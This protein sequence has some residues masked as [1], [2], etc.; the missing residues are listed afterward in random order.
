MNLAFERHYLLIFSMMVLLVS[1][2]LPF[3]ASADIITVSDN[4]G[5]YSSI[6][7]AIEDANSGDTLLIT[8]GIYEGNFTV[9]KKLTLEG[10]EGSEI[11]VT[12]KA[13]GRPVITIGP[14]SVE[15]TLV[16][17]RLHRAQGNICNDMAGGACPSG[18][19][20]TGRSSVRL[21]N[22]SLAENGREGLRIGGTARVK[23]EN[24]KIV[25]NDRYGIWLTGSSSLTVEDT[26]I[27]NNRNAVTAAKSTRVD[28]SNSKISSS[29]GYGISLFGRANLNLNDSRLA[30]NGQGGIRLENS[31]SGTLKENSINGNA[32]P[33][34][35]LQ[36]STSLK[37]VNNL[38]KGNQIGV[39]NHSTG[40]VVFKSNKILRNSIDL[41]GNLDGEL[42]TRYPKDKVDNIFLPNQ[43]YPTFQAAVDALL[44]GGTITLRANTSGGGVID[45]QMTIR[46]EN[47]P[48][49]LTWPRETGSP[50]LSL[51][52]GADLTILDTEISGS[53][54]SGIVLGG[55]AQLQIKSSNISN[56]SEE[57]LGLWDSSRV[58]IEKSKIAGNEGSGVRLVDSSKVNMA[59][60]SIEGNQIDGVLLAG[61]T[62]A[63]ISNSK[64]ASNDGQGLL[65]TGNS[66]VSL[67]GTTITLNE[68]NGL[69]LTGKSEGRLN[70]VEI[71]QN[72]GPGVALF[73]SSQIK[74]EDSDF[75]H[76]SSG[77]S[78]HDSAK[79]NI[80]ASRFLGNKIG[81]RV[82]GSK[83]FK[84]TIVGSGN[85]FSQNSHDFS[86]VS[87]PVKEKLIE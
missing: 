55:N 52:N 61:S 3:T 46:V 40:S 29:E 33:A 18:L 28:I 58:K 44:P 74:I 87:D 32:G 35:L 57:G 45:K 75:S 60:S 85:Q 22:V 66:L 56:N 51:I 5:E 8:E 34:V 26:S 13:R 81:V 15:V 17:V 64:I 2:F 72:E 42:R 62:R 38:V 10:K 49:Q 71:S 47:K 48:K 63:L 69:K 25:D 39:T 30:L 24:S 6:G 79:A 76:N 84:G 20:V 80:S 70:K 82:E 41:I 37:M 68:R 43:K 23:V 83:H 31:A 21:K 50:V 12:S 86:G 73:S 54:G 67:Y 19:S 53:G 7:K 65:L 77:I 11:R 78:L 4:G 59:E 1:T 14:S 16:N 9:N 36:G 27:I